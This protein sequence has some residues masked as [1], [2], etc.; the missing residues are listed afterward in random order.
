MRKVIETFIYEVPDDCEDF[1]SVRDYIWAANG[2]TCP[3][4]D[5]LDSFVP[6]VERTIELLENDS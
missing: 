4:Y 1:V 6:E 2:A 3:F 5:G